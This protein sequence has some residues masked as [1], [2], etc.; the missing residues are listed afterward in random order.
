M[1]VGFRCLMPAAA[2]PLFRPDVVRAHVKAFSLPAALD[3]LRG[4]L[5]SWAEL[6][7]SGR[8]DRFKETALLP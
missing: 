7:A 5:A 2:K 8:I 6:V 4:D 3:G 1:L